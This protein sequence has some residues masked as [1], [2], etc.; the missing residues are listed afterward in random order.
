VKREGSIFMPPV[1]KIIAVANQKGGV[2]KTTTIM[3]LASELAYLNRKVLLIDLDPQ[4]NATSGLGVSINKNAPSSYDWLSPVSTKELLSQSVIPLAPT[5]AIPNKDN[6][7]IVPS[8]LRLASAELNFAN[9]PHRELILK[10]SINKFIEGKAAEGISY[11]YVLIDCSPTLGLT[12]V[13]ALSAAQAVLTPVQ[14]EYYALEGLAQLWQTLIQ[15]GRKLNK[16][17]TDKWVVLTMY[18]KR[19]N[20]SSQIAN[21][22]QSAPQLK[23][24][25][26]ETIIPR[27]TKLAEAPSHGKTIRELDPRSPGAIAY[28]ALAE[29]VI[30]KVERD[31]SIEGTID[32]VLPI[33][34]S[35]ADTTQGK[36]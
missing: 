29:D 12:T 28:R 26:L 2:G 20:L 15:V 21:S 10:N 36:E 30:N 3:N 14:C 13:N 25:V 7:H 35:T 8:S 1:R 22:V 27:V 5:K 9:E 18:D 6:L 4:G 32:V 19:N 34:K 11:D 16:D 33:G 23:G 31:L 24:S 17:L